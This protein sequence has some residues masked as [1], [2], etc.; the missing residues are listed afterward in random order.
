MSLRRCVPRAA[1]LMQQALRSTS[2]NRVQNCGAP[3]TVFSQSI[4]PSIFGLSRLV[5]L[6]Y[7]HDETDNLGTQVTIDIMN[8]RRTKE[9]VADEG[10]DDDDE[11]TAN[12]YVTSFSSTGFKLSNTHGVVGPCILFPRTILSWN[13]ANA[14]DITPESL[15]LFSLL[16]PKLD[17]LV[18]GIGDGSI[19]ADEQKILTFCRRLGINVEILNTEEACATF[20]FLNGERRHVAAALIPPETVSLFNPELFLMDDNMSG[21]QGDISLIETTTSKDP[22]HPRN[23]FYNPEGVFTDHAVDSEMSRLRRENITKR[24]AAEM[25]YTEAKMK[26]EI[27]AMEDRYTPDGEKVVTELEELAKKELEKDLMEY[28]KT[29]VMSKRLELDL[30]HKERAYT[31]V[32]DGPGALEWVEEYRSERWAGVDKS[33]RF[34]KKFDKLYDVSQ[35]DPPPQ[36]EEA[37]K[38]ESGEEGGVGDPTLGRDDGRKPSDGKSNGQ[39]NDSDSIKEDCEETTVPPAKQ[40]S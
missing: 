27:E 10:G 16:E 31:S 13:V 24:D 40:K 5:Q 9:E 19:K 8:R 1:S 14:K 29:G 22:S 32:K 25:R 15:T 2:I 3:V 36:V 30:A 6:R 23:W 4:D 11:A 38:L 18:L 28:E 17:V 35:D 20:N 12:I 39:T 7:N 26:D 21:N 34:R 33:E 37:K